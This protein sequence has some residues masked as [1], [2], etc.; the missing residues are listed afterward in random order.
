LK[1]CELLYQQLIINLQDMLRFIHCF[2]PARSC[3]FVF[4]P[5]LSA[6]AA[7]GHH[8]MP[9]TQVPC[10]T[11]PGAASSYRTATAKGGQGSVWHAL[12]APDSLQATFGQEE[13]E[14]CQGRRVSA[15]NQVITSMDEA[16]K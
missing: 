5:H 10:S 7:S 3:G 14:R 6:H 9:T 8:A 15:Q 11:P 1:N 13:G 12:E 2:M 4:F 16:C